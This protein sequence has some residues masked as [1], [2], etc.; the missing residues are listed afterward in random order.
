MNDQISFTLFALDLNIG[1]TGLHSTMEHISKFRLFSVIIWVE[2]IFINPR[3]NHS[4][5]YSFICQKH[6]KIHHQKLTTTLMELLLFKK[7]TNCTFLNT[8]RCYS[9]NIFV[10]FVWRTPQWLKL[11]A[12]G[13]T[14]FDVCAQKKQLGLRFFFVRVIPLSNSLKVTENLISAA[15]MWQTFITFHSGVH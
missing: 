2:L 4:S 9:I 6:R 10:P 14:S 5:F 11:W 3:Y 13:W 8:S 12:D 15:S 7:H 1:F